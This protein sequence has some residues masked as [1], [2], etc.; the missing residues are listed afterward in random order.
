MPTGLALAI[1][2]VMVDKPALAASIAV[3]AI[4]IALGALAAFASLRAHGRPL[5]QTAN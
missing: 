3:L 5:P 4:G 2:F 1:T